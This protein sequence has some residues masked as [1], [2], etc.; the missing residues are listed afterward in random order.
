MISVHWR[1]RSFGQ[2]THHTSPYLFF[3]HTLGDKRAR[4]KFNR[5]MADSGANISICNDKTKIHNL[6]YYKKPLRANVAD[7]RPVKVLGYGLLKLHANDGRIVDI[8]VKY[9][10]HL[11]NILST[12]H[13]KK[14]HNKSTLTKAKIEDFGD[15]G[16]VT[17]KGTLPQGENLG[18]TVA[19]DTTYVQDLPYLD[20]EPIPVDLAEHSLPPDPNIVCSLDHHDDDDPDMPDISHQAA[21]QSFMS[22][23]DNLGATHSAQDDPFHVNKVQS[24]S[25]SLLWH[26]RLVHANYNDIATLHKSVEGVPKI[27]VPRANAVCPCIS[28]TTGK[29]CDAAMGKVDTH[30]N[31]THAIHALHMDFGFVQ[32]R[33]KRGDTEEEFKRIESSQGYN[34]YLLIKD[35]KTKYCWLFLSKNKIPPLD[36]IRAFMR[37]YRCTT[38]ENRW[39]R[40]DRGGEL[41]GSS[42][43]RTMMWEE[44]GYQP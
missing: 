30:N 32:S 13:L 42:A 9:A 27:P 8:P 2:Q 33:T 35:I 29:L 21:V 39:I 24:H 12:R 36:L 3:I 38:T 28:C 16:K 10:P 14:A 44:F 5:L 7:N 31:P 20:S 22:Y 17:L 18:S 37:K 26:N 4:A 19:F 11:P 25:L 6:K 43:F 15:N 34:S 41:N 23:V 40:T 1:M